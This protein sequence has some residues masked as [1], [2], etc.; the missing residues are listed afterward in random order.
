MPIHRTVHRFLVFITLAVLAACGDKGSPEQQVRAVIEQMER[1]AEDR[2]V[3][4]LTAH[5]S[6]EYRDANGRGAEEA[7]RYVRGYFIASQS[8]HLLTRIEELTF[9]MDGEARARVQVGMLGRDAA[10]QWDLAAELHTFKIAL[11]REDGEWRVTFLEVLG[12]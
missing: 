10:D 6:E 5:L 11:R 3:G 1:A 9:P 2:D 12:K 8:I 7:A 4:G